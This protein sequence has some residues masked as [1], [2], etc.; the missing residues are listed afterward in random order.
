[1]RRRA[2]LPAPPR[3]SAGVAARLLTGPNLFLAAVVAV[4]V[5]L[6][7]TVL[8]GQDTLIA[9]DILRNLP[10]WS[11]GGPPQP[12]RNAAVSDPLTQFLPWLH[13]VRDQWLHGHLPLWNPSTFGGAPLL[14]NDQSAPLSPFTLL[15]LPFAPATGYSLAMLLK[16]VVGGTGMAVFVRR[17]GA[18]R[19]AAI[20]AGVAYAGSS[21]MVVWL[22]HAQTAV[23][24][25]FPW[26]FACVE[27]WLQTRRRTALAGLAVVVAVQFLAGHAE[28]TVHLGLMLGFYVL[29]RSLAQDR[30]RWRALAGMVGAAALGTAIAAVQVLPFVAELRQSTLLTDRQASGAGFGHLQLSELIGW[31]IPNG[32][33]NPGIDGAAGRFPN[34]LEAAGFIGVAALL[35]AGIGAVSAWRR[36]HRSV[37]VALGVPIVLA[38]GVVYGPLSPLAGRLPFL[39]T[40]N[41]MRL[42]VVMCLGL[43]A[44][45]GLG[46]QAVTDRRG[47]LAARW[48]QV[49]SRALLAAG[50]ALVATLVGLGLVLVARG[51]G[52]DGLL[53]QFHGNIGFW[54]LVAVVS[55]GAAAALLAAAW[56]GQG[57]AAAA[58]LAC[59]VLTES[60]IYAGPF[61]P[62]VPVA[63]VPPPSDTIAW[64][65]AHAGDAKVAAQSLMLIPDLAAVYGLTDARG[66]DITIDP[67]VRLYW[68]RADPGYDDH[69]YYTFF[70]R[71]GTD[72]LA[73][74]GVRYYVSAPD[75]VP[76]G[77]S[78]V[79]TQ[80]GYVVSEVPQP[81]PFAFAAASVSTA[82]GPSQAVDT[83]AQDPLGAVVLESGGTTPPAAP[84][85]VRVTR[86][87]PGAV[88]LDVQASGAATVVVAQSYAADWSARVD[89]SAAAVWPADVLF[90]GIAVPA[91]HHTV[92][93]RYQPAAVSAGLALS[94]AGLLSLLALL[95]GPPVLARRRRLGAS[96]S[97]PQTSDL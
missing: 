63:E 41:N 55:T 45:A 66:V 73:A 79:L 44:L 95:A 81:R 7:S 56:L 59:L 97:P 78:T 9:G 86:R 27:I 30:D 46:F 50:G 89:D 15:A 39:S 38:A 20:V 61:Q 25:V 69:T 65:Q 17:L 77:A 84:A 33:G 53:R 49:G 52:V 47:T 88:D 70:S 11:T 14:G 87:D 76:A 34:Y 94:G 58:G 12:P 92:T 90:Q 72:W 26:A 82:A 68:S 71:P 31:L 83:L 75:A 23:A 80:P 54:V 28:T 6:W 91:G 40:S 2:D 64:L 3:D 1:V 35:L 16:L 21:F 37:V 22:G 96:Q 51:D 85:T 4:F 93:L 10:P 57:R 5:G 18:G 36:G 74:A 8:I 19:S 24:A 67:R 42:L 48:A 43:A 62:R 29:A 13:L 60:A 32:H